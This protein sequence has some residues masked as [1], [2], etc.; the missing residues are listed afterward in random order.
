MRR[1]TYS[2]IRINRRRWGL[3]QEELAFL[4]GLSSATAVSRI[5]RS[6]QAPTA[7][8]LIGY[9]LV[10]GLST[11]ELLP[12]FHQDIEDTVIKAARTLLAEYETRADKRSQRVRTLLDDLLKRLTSSD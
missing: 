3:T 6:K 11:P 9:A 1:R 10:F 5:E 8:A 2:Y 4:V 7:Q 12:T